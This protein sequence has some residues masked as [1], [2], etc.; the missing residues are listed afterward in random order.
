MV[1]YRTPATATISRQ[2]I[3]STFVQFPVVCFTLALLT[4][5]AYWR[6]AHLMWLNFSSWL[7][8]AGLVF[9]AVA[10]VAGIV[11][12]LFRRAARTSR[13]AWP[14]AV[15][16][17]LVLGLALVNSLIHARDG[18]TAVVPWGLFVSAATVVVMLVSAWLGRA[19]VYRHRVE[20]SHHG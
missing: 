20:V 14:H 1:E 3:Y 9:G 15:G 5:I 13:A 18:W 6:T 10:A 16:G 19:L 12:L 4:D 11:D 17:L 2:P 7:L 8:F